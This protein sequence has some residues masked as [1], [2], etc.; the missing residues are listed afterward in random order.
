MWTQNSL[1]ELLDEDSGF[2]DL[3]GLGDSTND[4][5]AVSSAAVAGAAVRTGITLS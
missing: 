4:I 5:L 2:M 3:K 1:P